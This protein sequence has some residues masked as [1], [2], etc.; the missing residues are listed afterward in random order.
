MSQEKTNEK[1]TGAPGWFHRAS[2]EIGSFLG[3]V[4][5]GAKV[6]DDKLRTVGK[7]LI[8]REKKDEEMT[9]EDK[10][11]EKE[12]Q[13]ELEN[14]LHVTEST[15]VAITENLQI[16]KNNIANDL[17]NVLW[18]Q[19]RKLDTA[20][21]VIYRLSEKHDDL[22]EELR[23]FYTNSAV[24]LRYVIDSKEGAVSQR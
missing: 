4:V 9:E 13:L 10:L 12:L 1:G 19:L 14:A 22:L 5:D 11:F 8:S 2:A 23:S 24:E 20:R 18:E 16:V 3:N 6:V 17:V 7:K 21:L 15:K